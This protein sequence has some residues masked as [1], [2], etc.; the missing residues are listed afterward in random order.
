MSPAVRELLDILDLEQIEVNL[1]RG[2]SPQIGRQRVYGGQVIAQALA[3]ACRT[4]PGRQPH[5]LHAYFLL[6][7]DPNA[8]IVYE[9]DRIRDG[10]SFT[11]R[12]VKASQHGKAIFSMSASFHDDE[13][14]LEHQ[15]AMPAMPQPDALGNGEAIKQKILERMPDTVR[16]YYERERAIELRPVEPGRYLGERMADGRFNIWM[17]AGDRLPDDPVLHRGVLAYASDMMLLDTALAALGRTLFEPSIMAAS[18]DHALWFHRPFRADEWLLYAQDGPN[19]HGARGFARGL[20]YTA[21][22]TLVASV[23]QEGMIRQKRQP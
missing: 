13:P 22:G 21:D 16:R 11:T 7:G 10:K 5:S 17:R 19:L 3:A 9:V 18:L 8:P 23:V 1:F 6:A 15:F 14:S 4:V 20:I 2:R 12:G